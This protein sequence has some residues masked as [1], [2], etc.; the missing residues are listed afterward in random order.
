MRE[1]RKLR[2]KEERISRVRAIPS[3][4]GT[5]LGRRERWT[6]QSKQT[7][8]CSLGNSMSESR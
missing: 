4:E 1:D 3:K 6:R 8:N 2:G 5:V 7:H